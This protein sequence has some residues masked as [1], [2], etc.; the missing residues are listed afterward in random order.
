MKQQQKSEQELITLAPALLAVLPALE[1]MLLPAFLASPPPDRGLLTPDRGLLTPERGLPPFLALLATLPAALLPFLAYI[2]PA[3][4]SFNM[5]Q[6]G[7]RTA[8]YSS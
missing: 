8:N 2:M 3:C 7:C 6:S 1:A 5:L 4:I